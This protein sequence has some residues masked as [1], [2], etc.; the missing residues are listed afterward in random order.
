GSGGQPVRL[1]RAIVPKAGGRTLAWTRSALVAQVVVRLADGCDGLAG[2]GDG[3]LVAGI[4]GPAGVDCLPDAEPD[5]RLGQP[6]F[7]LHLSGTK[8]R[9]A[10]AG[11]WFD[12]CGDCMSRTTTVKGL[13]LAAGSILLVSFAQL[14]QKWGMANLPD[15]SQWPT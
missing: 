7:A 6:G 14:A 5:F 3:V 15:W 10:L 12:H 1:R 2:P 4:A 11:Y 8:R 9:P 13:R